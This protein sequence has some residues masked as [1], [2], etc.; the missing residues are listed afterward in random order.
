MGVEI[1][2]VLVEC[3]AAVAPAL[4]QAVDT[5]PPA[6][7]RIACYHFGWTDEHGDPALTPGGKMVRPV[8]TLLS[9]RAVGGRLAD[10]VPAA[11]AV[12]LVHNFSLLHDDIMDGDRTRRHRPS[13]WAVFGVPAAL[14]AGDALWALALRVLADRPDGVRLLTAALWDLVD[15]QAA[16]TDFPNRSGVTV[17]E[18]EAMAAGKTGAVMA[19]ACALGALT[20]GGTPHQVDRMHHMGRQLGLAFQLTDDLLGIWGD[21]RSTGKPGTDLVNRRKSL[22]VVAALN[23]GTGAGTELAR[24]YGRPLAGDEIDRAAELV[25]IAGGRS[26]ARERV[27]HHLRT[28]RESLG[29]AD[30]DPE[31]AAHLTSL[32]GHL[33]H[34]EH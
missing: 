30:P 6:M 25:E 9:A 33:A 20:G 24:L 19:C 26:W 10:A 32:A 11:V 12:E 1:E 3:Q 5:L 28:A 8:L 29:A 34:R 22:P 2:Q 14:L 13:A 15:G 18:C 7:R 21:P 27:A 31:V 16:D 17:A 23:S 4:R